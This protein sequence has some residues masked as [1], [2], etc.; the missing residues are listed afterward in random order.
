MILSEKQLEFW[1]APFHRWNIKCGATRSGKTYLDYYNIPRRI[2]SLR[3]KDG[4][5]VILGNTRG[6]L[7]R[8]ILEPLQN[9]W[10]TA[11][12]SDIHADNTVNLFGERCF[13]LGADNVKH[14]DKIRGSSIKYCYGDEIVTWSQDVFEMLKSRL[15]KP[16]SRFDGTCNPS[17]PDHWLKRFVESDADV[18]YQQYTIFD[19]PFLDPSVRDEMIK[20]H[21]GVFYKRNILGEWA[22]AEGL[23]YETFATNEADYLITSDNV[24]KNDLEYIC[25]GQDFGGNKS[26]HTFCATGITRDRRHLYVLASEEYDAKGTP[27]EFVIEHLDAFC[28]KIADRYGFVDYVFADSAEQTIINSERQRLPWRIRNSIKYEIVD[29][30]RCEDI[31]FSSGRIKIVKADNASLLSALRSAVWDEKAGDD[32]RMDIPGVTNIC[33]LDAFEYSWEQFIDYLT[34]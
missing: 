13:F 14:A 17:Y 33:P 2:R 19:N 26:K 31:L 18:F 15:D 28:R 20:E 34:R 23:I 8:N 32:K 7:Q 4:L 24:P 6:T 25:V 12:V 3:G 21:K 11:L 29:R 16:Y 1:N 5:V 30:I 27:V 9:I 10:T 22:L